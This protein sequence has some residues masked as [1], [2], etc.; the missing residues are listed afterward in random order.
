MLIF[1]FSLNSSIFASENGFVVKVTSGPCGSPKSQLKGSGTIFTYQGMTYVLTSEHVV[2]HSSQMQ[3]CHTVS[4]TSLKNQKATLLFADWGMGIALLKLSIPAQESF[5]SFPQDFISSNG[6][7]VTIAGSP[8][9][10]V[11]GIIST[12]GLIINDQS[13]RLPS[14]LLQSALEIEGAHGEFG[15]SGG[16]IIDETSGKSIFRAMLS[17]QV[18]LMRPGSPTR[19]S[20]WDSSEK[21]QNQLLGIKVEDINKAL[22]R[23]FQNPATFKVSFYRSPLGQINHTNEIVTNGLIFKPKIELQNKSFNLSLR[24][25]GGVD[26]IGIGGDDS[27]NNSPF[28]SLDVNIFSGKEE[29]RTE[30]VIPSVSAEVEKIKGLIYSNQKLELP[31]LLFQG[32]DDLNSAISLTSKKIRS[33]DDY[34]DLLSDHRFSMVIR[35]LTSVNNQKAQQLGSINIELL[36]YFSIADL[37][38]ENQVFFTALQTL[39]T[40]AL[41][42]NLDLIN[43]KYLT[44]LSSRSSDVDHFWAE[45]LDKDFDRS[46]KILQNVKYFSKQCKY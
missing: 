17:H 21:Y 24:R 13:E 19:A 20:E 40:M 23:Y 44:K 2:Y 15:M 35:N 4:N 45:L 36:S 37:Q 6:P 27:D 38:V 46:T 28:I 12:Q 29:F 7:N 32:E 43:C 18:L 9:D 39:S 30:W 11:N 34:F 5:L 16:P 1:S 22:N 10:E 33:I 25:A 3:F 31:F 42:D 26:P 8:Y 41:E 14:V